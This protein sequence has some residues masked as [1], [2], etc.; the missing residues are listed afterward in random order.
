[1]CIGAL[2]AKQHGE[3]VDHRDQRRHV[4]ATGEVERRHAGLRHD[5]GGH[6]GIR[7]CPEDHSAHRLHELTKH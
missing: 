1:M 4:R 7:G 5:G 3:A 6:L 2:V